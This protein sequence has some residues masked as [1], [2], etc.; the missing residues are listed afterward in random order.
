MKYLYCRLLVQTQ[1]GDFHALA[2][3]CTYVASNNINIKQRYNVDDF[4]CQ[5]RHYKAPLHK[6]IL[7]ENT[8]TCP[9]HAACFNVET[10]DIED[11]PVLDALPTYKT[12]VKGGTVHVHIPSTPEKLPMSRTPHMCPV[13]SADKRN[14]VIVGGGAAGIT[15]AQTLREQGFQGM[16]TLITNET[17]LPYDRPKLSKNLEIA[18]DGK[19]PELRSKDF[20]VQHG[21]SVRSLTEVRNVNTASRVVTVQPLDQDGNPRKDAVEQDI[22]YDKLL[23]ATGGKPRRFQQPEQF[24]I[25]GADLKNVFALRNATDCEAI[26]DAVHDIYDR[27]VTEDK[28]TQGINVVIV[29][30]SFI[31]MEAASYFAAKMKRDRSHQRLVANV[32][33]IGMEEQPFERVLGRKVGKVMKRLAENAGITFYM[34]AR[35]N[36]FLGDDEGNVSEVELQN[37]PQSIVADVVVIG[38]GIIP[39]TDYLEANSDITFEGGA[40]VADSRL[41]AAEDVY[42]AGDIAKFTFKHAVDKKRA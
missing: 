29:G 7:Y 33:V 4:L 37:S 15:A 40:V 14:F 26:N 22:R 38:A 6:G 32:T 23:C 36:E 21:I 17:N 9:W 10:G 25:P 16:I 3:R 5:C 20:F 24:T 41:K 39:A 42:V 31:G 27:K 34:K 2:P 11:G 35:V 30:S 18:N 12:S 1:K 8:V 13:G 28:D 19:A